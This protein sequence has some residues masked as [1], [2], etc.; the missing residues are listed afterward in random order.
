MLLLSWKKRW[1]NSIFLFLISWFKKH[2]RGKN[3]FC[4]SII[5]DFFVCN[6]F[7][8]RFKTTKK[9]DKTLHFC[10][11]SVTFCFTFFFHHFPCFLFH[12][13]CLCSLSLFIFLF[14]SFCFSPFFFLL[15]SPFFLFFCI[16]CFLICFFSIAVFAYPLFVLTHFSSFSFVLDIILLFFLFF[17][18]SVYVFCPNKFNIFC[19]QCFEDEMGSLIFEQSFLLCF[20]LCFSSLRRPY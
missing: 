2:L 7:S 1:K 20:V 15:V 5:F 18:I 19:G 14:I 9:S 6:L 12:H 4:F 16:S 13:C 10:F 3:P 8:L 17:F 11:C